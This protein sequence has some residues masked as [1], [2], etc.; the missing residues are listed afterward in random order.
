[1]N[2]SRQMKPF[3]QNIDHFDSLNR[4]QQYFSSSITESSNLYVS[5]L[6]Q[7]LK[8]NKKELLH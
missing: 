8:N 5:S 6:N 1:M 7:K 2:S 3:D 4:C